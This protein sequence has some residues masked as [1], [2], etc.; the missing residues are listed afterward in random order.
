MY[1][2]R[3]V[4]SRRVSDDPHGNSS[5]VNYKT[6][7]HLEQSHTKVNQASQYIFVIKD[8]S[9]LEK[10]LS[11]AHLCHN[12]TKLL[13]TRTSEL[14]GAQAF[15]SKA[16]SLSGAE[17]IGLVETLNSDIYQIG[18]A[19]ADEFGS[20]KSTVQE[21]ELH[22]MEALSRVLGKMMIQM[23]MSTHRENLAL[24]VQTALQAWSNFVAGSYQLY[25]SAVQILG[26]VRFRGA[27]GEAY[28]PVRAAL[29]VQARGGE[30]GVGCG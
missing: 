10:D 8:I 22:E 4:K 1:L 12:R 9:R 20:G 30:R 6:E 18:C 7:S 27:L 16:D 11:K 5:K 19:V 23:L 26:C 25:I 2:A 3:A 24:V 28:P 14:K 21:G 29:Q 13:A 15:L 17:V